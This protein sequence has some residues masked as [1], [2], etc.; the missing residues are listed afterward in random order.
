MRIPFYLD[1]LDRNYNAALAALAPPQPG[2]TA[3]L[4]NEWLVSDKLRRALVLRL[5][6]D[7]AV[8]REQFD[9]ARVELEVALRKQSQESQRVQLWLRGGLAVA[10]AGLGRRA[11]AITQ[12]DFVMASDPLKLD[13]IEGP[14]YMQHVALAH[15][16]MGN[17]VAAI[18]V[19]ERL[20]SVSAPVS[21]QSLHLEPFWDPLRSEPR[22]AQLVSATP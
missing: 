14:K 20:L 22:F 4:L 6:G 5:R 16:L 8:A 13:A 19:L 21:R 12:T 17:R 10:Y 1:V 18:D 9:S 15:V 11:D 7:S 2:L 3:S